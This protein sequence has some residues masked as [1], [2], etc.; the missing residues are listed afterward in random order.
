MNG[1]AKL[2]ALG[3][4]DVNIDVIER[5]KYRLVLRMSHY[6]ERLHGA[7]IPD[8]EMTI[9]VY[10]MAET[11]GVLTYCDCFGSRKVFC[12]ELMAFSPLAKVELNHFL[13]QWLTKMIADGRHQ[14]KVELA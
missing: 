12:P 3:H 4:A 8:P 13:D 1:P 7:A 14:L 5:H 2:T 6:L 9:E 11:V 10:L